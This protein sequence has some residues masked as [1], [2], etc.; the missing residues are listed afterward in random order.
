MQTPSFNHLR[1]ENF[2]KLSDEQLESIA[3]LTRFHID[4]FD[5]VLEQGL[6]HAIK[7]GICSHAYYFYFRFLELIFRN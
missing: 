5:W 4:S 2:N 6:G 3:G 1:P 7:V